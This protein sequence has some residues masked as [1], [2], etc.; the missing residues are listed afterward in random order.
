MRQK[1]YW[2]SGKLAETIA[3]WWLRLHG[4]AIV[5]RRLRT[6]FAEVDIVAHH[7]WHCKQWLLVE[8]KFRPDGDLVAHAL[9]KR[10]YHRLQRA[11]LWLQSQGYIRAN[12]SLRIDYIAVSSPRMGCWLQHFKNI[13]F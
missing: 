11:G 2:S 6:P 9:S 12:D 13:T 4:Y 8:V 10:Q 5:E 1:T 7:R 3:C